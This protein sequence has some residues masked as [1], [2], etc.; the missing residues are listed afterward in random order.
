MEAGGFH[1]G[2]GG[3]GTSGWTWISSRAG[4]HPPAVDSWI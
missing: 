4:N 3:R 1:R 2:D